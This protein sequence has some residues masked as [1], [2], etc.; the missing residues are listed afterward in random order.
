MTAT[1]E[2][3]SYWGIMCLTS[4]ISNVELNIFHLSVSLHQASSWDCC[5]MSLFINILW[6]MQAFTRWWIMNQDW[7]INVVT[8]TWMSVW[9]L[10]Q[11]Q[12]NLLS[13][14]ENILNGPNIWIYWW[15]RGCVF[16]FCGGHNSFIIL[17]RNECG[18]KC[19]QIV[20]NWNIVSRLSI[21]IS[22]MHTGL[23]YLHKER[24]KK[25]L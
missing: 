14:Q 11:L 8:N 9:E 4:R 2:W 13:E 19:F 12:I 1:V 20:L 16:Q 25:L 15:K 10:L 24:Q 5:Q 3:K 17:E 21:W 23:N 18:P 6:K 7:R 22:L